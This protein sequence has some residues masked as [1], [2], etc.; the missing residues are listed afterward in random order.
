M[1]SSENSD[2]R[3]A[4]KAHRPPADGGRGE[5]IDYLGS[6]MGA[7]VVDEAEAKIF[8]YSRLLDKSF[9]NDCFHRRHSSKVGLKKRTKAPSAPIGPPQRGSKYRGNITSDAYLVCPILQPE[10]FQLG[11][12]KMLPSLAFNTL[13]LW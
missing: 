3:K 8:L 9:S 6:T 11:F 2:T 4:V 7:Q 10:K 1:F 12:C 5:T 13:A